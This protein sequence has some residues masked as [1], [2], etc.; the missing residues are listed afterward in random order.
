[1]S[2]DHCF[3]PEALSTVVST[4]FSIKALDK[5]AL[6][7]VQW[8]EPCLGRPFFISIAQVSTL[9]GVPQPCSLSLPLRARRGT[10]PVKESPRSDAAQGPAREVAWAPTR[11][12]TVRRMDPANHWVFSFPSASAVMF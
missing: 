7:K 9:T 4:K 8:P 1:M 11:S 3:G 5:G 12:N 6:D 2:S 10:L